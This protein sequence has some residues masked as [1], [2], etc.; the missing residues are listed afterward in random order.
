MSDNAPARP[1]DPAH[2]GQ[3]FADPLQRDRSALAFEHAPTSMWIQDLHLLK[4]RLDRWRAGG[5]DDL[6]TH[7]AADSARV[8]E[9]V[10]LIRVTAV[11]RETLRLYE[12]AD[13]AA[14]MAK[15]REIFGEDQIAS[16]VEVICQLWGGQVATSVVT[17]NYTARGRLLDVKYK[18]RLLPGHEAD[19]AA[20][21]ICVEDVSVQQQALRLLE[22]ARTHDPLTGLHNRTFLTET[23]ER[24]E[25]GG[26][27][28]ALAVFD[29]NGLKSAN[30]RFG[31]KA[32]DDLLRRMGRLLRD[33]LPP[34]CPAVR[35]GGDEFVAI[36]TGL[37]EAGANALIA[38]LARAADGNEGGAWQVPLSFSTG[39][40]WRRA[41]EGM[42][43]LLARADRNMYR[44]K[45]A[46]HGRRAVAGAAAR[47]TAT[48]R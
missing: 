19:W 33:H 45:R 5:I 9:L 44:S 38:R 12:V 48:G 14:L 20:Y 10:A 27:P 42:D 2:P 18:G 31:H 40:A 11:N 13:E 17:R 26:D 36:V 35:M 23:L 39:L 43:Q 7:L 21:L 37:D 30:D 28:V 1:T 8:E 46:F 16:F 34:T 24:L 15:V 29:L 41:G 3:A 22:A 6:R 25:V 32:G 4:E 47:T